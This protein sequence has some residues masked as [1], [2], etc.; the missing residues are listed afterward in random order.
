VAALSTGSDMIVVQ[1]GNWPKGD[2]WCY[3]IYCKRCNF[4]DYT[5]EGYDGAQDIRTAH[6]AVCPDTIRAPR[7]RRYRG[8][9]KVATSPTT[10]PKRKK[11]DEVD[12]TWE[13][14]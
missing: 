1:T 5:S 13:V 9:S 3:K 12:E 8:A 11:I 7:R 4:E 2:G 14:L 6:R 10:Q